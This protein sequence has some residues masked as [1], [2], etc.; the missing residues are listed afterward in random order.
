MN[1]MRSIRYGID[2]AVATQDE[3][4]RQIRRMVVTI[5]FVFVAFVLR[6]VHSTMSAVS[7]LLQ[8]VARSCPGVTNSPCDPT[9]HNV[10]TLMQQWMTFTPEFQVTIVLVSSPL[11]LLVALWGMTSKQTLQAMKSRAQA[12]AAME[13]TLLTLTDAPIFNRAQ[14]DP[15]KTTHTFCECSCDALLPQRHRRPGVAL[16]LIFFTVFVFHR[17]AG[18]G[19]G[20]L[21]PSIA[22][23]QMCCQWACDCWRRRGAAVLGA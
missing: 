10:F 23:D 17:L 7:H 14:Y 15:E 22:F 9:C 4:R 11:T 20:P 16:V 1:L 12:A 21:D 2:A 13:Q 6:S 19:C 5:A 3:G 8:D 18:A